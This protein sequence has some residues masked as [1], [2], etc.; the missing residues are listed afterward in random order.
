MTMIFT[1]LDGPP[2]E[3]VYRTG[4]Q[5]AFFDM[6][7]LHFPLAVRSFRPGDRLAPLGLKG[8]QKV[9]KIFIDRKITRKDR[10]RCPLLVCGDRILWV[11]GLRQSEIGKIEPTTRHWL[12]VE[13]A[14]CLT[15]QDDYF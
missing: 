5:T 14:G 13:A 8:T 7:K 11:V 1:C 4:Q 2:E 15:R 12:K 9:K 3:D 10:R 6:D